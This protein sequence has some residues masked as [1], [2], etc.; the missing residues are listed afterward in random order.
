MDKI[1]DYCGK[2]YKLQYALDKHKIP[3][4]VLFVECVKRVSIKEPPLL[5]SHLQPPEENMFTLK[6]VNLILSEVIMQNKKMQE[7][8]TEIKKFIFKTKIRINI[9]DWLPQHVSPIYLFDTFV[10]NNIIASSFHVDCLQENKIIDIIEML[11]TDTLKRE[12]DNVLP[13]F[14]FNEKI[15]IYD[16]IE[17]KEIWREMNR[18]ELIQFMNRVHKKVMHELKEWKDVNDLLIKTDQIY[19]NINHKLSMK[20]M[21][22]DFNKDVTLNKIRAFLFTIFKR[23]VKSI[24]EYE[25]I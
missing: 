6:Q 4:K 1:C 14:C 21:D 12:K 16:M 5:Q 15:Y 10:T 2:G 7:E 22:I 17:E 24:V 9:L 13:L 18:R 20:I 8:L 19:Y 3:C 23:D 25:F 11:L